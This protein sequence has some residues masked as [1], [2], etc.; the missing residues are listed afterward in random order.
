[1]FKV[2]L[3]SWSH[4][5]NEKNNTGMEEETFWSQRKWL[6]ALGSSG[7]GCSRQQAHQPLSAASSCAAVGSL[8]QRAQPPTQA[9]CGLASQPC[10]AASLARALTGRAQGAAVIFS[11]VEKMNF[12][13]LADPV[14][15]PAFFFFSRKNG[16]FQYHFRKLS[17]FKIVLKKFV[18]FE[19][20]F[21][22]INIFEI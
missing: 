5:L 6:L 3:Q 17:F 15:R 9:A 21:W 16:I 8:R 11:F 4:C 22:E 20:K 7:H 1:M 14:T 13:A 2:Q 10:W 18:I 19:I 12:R